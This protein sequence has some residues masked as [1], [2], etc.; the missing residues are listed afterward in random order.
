MHIWQKKLNSFSEKNAKFLFCKHIKKNIFLF[1]PGSC[2]TGPVL[3][4]PI[5]GSKHQP[6]KG[7]IR[8]NILVQSL[9]NQYL[10]ANISLKKGHIR[11]NILVQSLVNQ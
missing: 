11:L 2:H 8:L 7:H 4:P 10:G 1:H 9:V 6:E 5:A 3:G